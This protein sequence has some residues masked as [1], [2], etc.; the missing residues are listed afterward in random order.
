M[1]P[2]IY[3]AVLILLFCFAHLAQAEEYTP[4]LFQADYTIRIKGASIANMTRRFT[5]LES[6]AYQYHS[7]T[8]TTGL[9]SLFR[10]DHIIERSHWQLDVRKLIP[11][12]YYYEHSGGKKDRR[13][14]ILFDWTNNRITNSIDG[15]SWKMPAAPNVLDKLLYQLAIMYDLQAGKDSLRYTVADG[16]KTKIYNFE[17]LGEEIIKTPLGD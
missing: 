10:K 1:L 4:T 15:S 16:G 9:L 11:L 17:I 8:R 7:E 12:D 3:Q 2:P 13:V 5:R 6:G 14:K